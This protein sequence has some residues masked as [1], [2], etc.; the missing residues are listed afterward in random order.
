MICVATRVTA[1]NYQDRAMD[2]T[3]QIL[4]SG[5]FVLIDLMSNTDLLKES[6]V[7]LSARGEIEINTKGEA[8]VAGIFTAGDVT[9]VP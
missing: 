4:L 9:T 1:L 6:N 2:E 8:S 5:I 7:V 3:L